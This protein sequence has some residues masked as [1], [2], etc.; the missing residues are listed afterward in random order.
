MPVSED[1]SVLIVGGGAAGLSSAAALVHRGIKSLVLEQDEKIGATWSRRY[2]SLRLHTTR[3]F[4][5]LS[6]LAIPRDRPQYLSKD[7]Y[8]A[9]LKDYAASLNLNVALGERVDALKPAS[10]VSR[11]GW[12]VST[13]A[14]TRRARAVI[15]ATGLCAE[16]YM[17]AFA[18]GEE[19]AGQLLH[20]AHYFDA[21]AYQGQTVLVI[22]LGNSGAEIAADLAKHGA[23]RVLLSVRTP[24]PI[25]SR[26]MFGI[27]PVQLFGIA[28]SPLGI[29]RVVDRVSQAMRRVSLGDLKRYGLGPATWGAFTAQR[30]AV[31]DTGF[32]EQLK[33]GRVTIRPAVDRFEGN[34]VVYA[35]E[36]R[37][38]VDAVI[39]ATGFRSGLERILPLSIPIDERGRLR[40]PGGDRTSSRTT[41]P[42]LHFVGFKET[43]RGQLYEINQQSRRVASDIAQNLR[44]DCGGLL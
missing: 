34:C 20:S 24:P 23:G 17:P 9:Y 37:E 2:D 33:L 5:G 13:T 32:I 7:E 8:A 4:S 25:V 26:E 38:A 43:V 14:G 40:F 35:N 44:A 36:A 30:P 29:P 19:F 31:I 22:G 41:M 12:L 18:G 10:D 3:R 28:L 39:A 11:L 42:G 15:V 6:H 16:P 27:V 21:A 1:P